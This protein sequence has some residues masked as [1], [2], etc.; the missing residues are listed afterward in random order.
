MYRKLK[1]DLIFAV[2][3]MSGSGAVLTVRARRCHIFIKRSF[4]PQAIAC[5]CVRVCVSACV[6]E[7]GRRVRMRNRRG[8]SSTSINC[9]TVLPNKRH[10]RAQATCAS[11][12]QLITLL[13]TVIHWYSYDPPA[14]ST[15]ADMLTRLQKGT[16]SEA[17]SI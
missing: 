15:L 16:V 7:L 8:D 4:I 1:N 5:A 13:A 14:T 6:H 11:V 9:D 10:Q 17:H 3:R 12:H 2:P